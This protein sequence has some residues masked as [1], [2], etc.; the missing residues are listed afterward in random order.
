MQKGCRCPRWVKG[1]W[2]LPNTLLQ[3]PQGVPNNPPAV[4][5]TVANHLTNHLQRVEDTYRVN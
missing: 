5:V 1:P 3:L 2:E 4:G